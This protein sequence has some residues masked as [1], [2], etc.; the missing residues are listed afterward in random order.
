MT[1]ELPN[2]TIR[3]AIKSDVPALFALIHELAVFEKAPEEVI[4]TE[5]KMLEEGFGESPYFQAFVAEVDDQVVGMSLVYFRYSTWKGKTVYL[6]DLIVNEPFRNR[7]IGKLLF[8]RTL[9][10]AREENCARM[11]WQVLDWNEP[12]ILFYKNYGAQFD[13]GWVNA[14]IDI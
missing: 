4:N 14:F 11:T 13:N 6:E 10:F 7:G 5:E 1:K 2:A 12:A 8:E 3:K 9:A